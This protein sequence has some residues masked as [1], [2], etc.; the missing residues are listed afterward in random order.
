MAESIIKRI[1]QNFQ[2]VLSREVGTLTYTSNSVVTQTSLNRCSVMRYGKICVLYLN[3]NVEGVT[4]SDFVKIGTCSFS[5]S[6]MYTGAI[7]GTSGNAT[8]YLNG[9]NLTIY[10]PTTHSGWV[11]GA[12]VWVQP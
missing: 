2:E 9:T 12:L 10:K 3:L 4:T 11:R 1:R 8:L 7:Q 6:A 5:G